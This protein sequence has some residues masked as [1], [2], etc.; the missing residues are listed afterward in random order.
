MGDIVC[1]SGGDAT[2]APVPAAADVADPLAR[3]HRQVLL[4]GIG[5]EGQ[6]RLLAAHAVV[7]GCGAL[8][9]IIA[10]LLARAGVGT[11]T[12][13]DRDVV[14]LTNLQRQ[15]LFDEADAAAGLPKAEAAAAKLRRINSAVAV[16]PVVADFN[17]RSAERLVLAGDGPLPSVVLDATDNFA[18]RYLNNDLCVKHSLAY[19]YGAAVG[20]VGMVTT[21]LPRR[22]PCLRCVF[23]DM[24]PPGTTPTCDTAGV[25]GPVTAAVGAVQAAEAIKTLT[26]AEPA[27]GLLEIDLWSGGVR[28]IDLGSPR[29]DCPCCARGEYP[30]LEGLMAAGATVLCGRNSVQVNPPL[31]AVRGRLDLTDLAQRLS[32]HGSF[33]ATR[34][35]LRGVLRDEGLELTVF[36]DARAIVR[37]TIDPA[38]ALTVYSRYIGV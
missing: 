22:T 11:L 13:I 4:P 21:I 9:T 29:E 19:I 1:G 26:G 38:T 14:E 37:G 7:V 8:G 32:V 18:T 3:Y 2:S 5:S 35:T 24:P 23:P 20:T 27:R 28:R 17:H 34:L 25:L 6:R 33:E 30:F 15:T 36:P 12:I 16:R 31:E 10:D